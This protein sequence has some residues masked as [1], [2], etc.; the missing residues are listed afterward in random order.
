M[1]LFTPH[2]TRPIGQN[3][4][5]QGD[6]YGVPD[7]KEAM[8]LADQDGKWINVWSKTGDDKPDPADITTIL[9]SNSVTSITGAATA[10]KRT[11]P[12][13]PD[14]ANNVV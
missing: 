7:N 10:G 12:G 13:A 1:D 2:I 14:G 11:E 3:V 8:Y 9:D 6:T 4:T 5:V